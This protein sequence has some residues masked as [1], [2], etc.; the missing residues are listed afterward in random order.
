MDDREKRG[1][2]VGFVQRVT[3]RLRKGRSVARDEWGWGKSGERAK[4][5]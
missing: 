2:L 3:N 4:L 1:G 5:S